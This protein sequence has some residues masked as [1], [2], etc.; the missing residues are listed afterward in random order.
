MELWINLE[1]IS[2]CLTFFIFFLNK[3]AFYPEKTDCFIG[4]VMRFLGWGVS[5]SVVRPRVPSPVF[6]VPCSVP[7]VPSP[8]FRPPCSVPRVPSPVFRPPCSVP[9]VPSPVFRPPC[10]VPRVP[11]PVFRWGTSFFPHL[12]S[13]KYRHNSPR[14]THDHYPGDLLRSNE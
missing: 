14:Y 12:W 7:R 9:R 5:F 8:V 1:I 2:N 6:R 10:S 4:R 13:R 11:S 3:W